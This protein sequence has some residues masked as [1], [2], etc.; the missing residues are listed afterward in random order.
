MRW[1]LT[2]FAS[3]IFPPVACLEEPPEAFLELV[4][5]AEFGMEQVTS[6]VA[7]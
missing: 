6:I 5:R 7:N 3:P 4:L 1:P 2:V